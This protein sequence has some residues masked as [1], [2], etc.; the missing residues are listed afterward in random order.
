MRSKNLLDLMS[1]E[2]RERALERGRKR[3]ERRKARK[4]LDISPE[5]FDICEFGYYFGWDALLAVRRG[6]TVAPGTNEKE[7]LSM[8]EVQILLEGARKVWYTKLLESARTNMASITSAF[9]NEPRR[10]LETQLKTV[11][12]MAEVKE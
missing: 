2:E 3:Q 10:S 4:G 12:E 8:D 5:I 7:L 11:Q 1:S 9:S 6:Y